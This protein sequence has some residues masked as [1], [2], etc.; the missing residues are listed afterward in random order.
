MKKHPVMNKT[1][2]IPEKYR[3]AVYTVGMVPTKDDLNL[4]L[5]TWGRSFDSNVKMVMVQEG[6]PYHYKDEFGRRW[7][8][9]PRDKLGR[10][11]PAF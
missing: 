9:D 11:D 7:R 10:G 2:S 5:T 6:E 3:T 4:T 8:V 1:K